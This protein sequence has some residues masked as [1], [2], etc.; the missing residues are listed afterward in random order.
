MPR[1]LTI[2]AGVYGRARTGDRLNADVPGWGGGDHVG[3]SMDYERTRQ[4]LTLSQGATVIGRGTGTVVAGDAP[5]AGALPYRLVVENSRDADVSPY[6]PTTRTEWA[7]TSKAPAADAQAVLPLIQLDY[8]VSTDGAGRADRD[9]DLAVTALHLPGATGAGRVDRTS[10]E[11]SYDDGHRWQRPRQ[12]QNGRYAL[13]APRGA[14]FASLRVSA[15]DTAG[16]TVT[17]TV[18]RA[19]GLR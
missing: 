11:V 1:G 16:N 18:A 14:A 8:A 3:M 2:R 9:A 15:T 6:S 7:F 19:F 5:S 12:R 4:I 13:D 10:V 17:Q